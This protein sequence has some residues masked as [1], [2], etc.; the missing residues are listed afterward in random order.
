MSAILLAGAVVSA[1]SASAAPAPATARPAGAAAVAAAA[2]RPA[3]AGTAARPA[4]AAADPIDCGGWWHFTGND[5]KS[6]RMVRWGGTNGRPQ[7]NLM[8]GKI[9][10]IQHGWA[11]L[12]GAKQ[13]DWVT[14]DVTSDGGRTWGY[15]GPFE[16]RWD[17]DIVIT[18]AARTSSDPNLQFRACGAPRGVPG[19]RAICTAP[20]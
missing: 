13:G 3:V 11:Q 4:V 20:W 1:P 12:S 6:A 17:G 14:L 18:P 16:A 7:F 2:A 9:Q 19:S 15:C 5:P 8:Y 10:G